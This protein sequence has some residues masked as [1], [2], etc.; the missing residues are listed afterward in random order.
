MVEGSFKKQFISG[1]LYTS[2][3]KYIGVFVSL[4]VT[5][6]LSRILTP[7]DFGVVAIATIFINIFS[8]VSTMGIAPA[9]VQNKEL[10][11]K[12]I[13]DIFSLTFWLGLILSGLFIAITPVIADYYDNKLLEDVLNA[14]T[15]CIFFSVLNTVPNALLLKEKQFKFIALRT[16]YVQ[17]SIGIIAITGAFYG[18]GVYALLVNPIIGSIIL[19]IVTY[20]KQKI[21][22]NLKFH[23]Y[24]INKIFSYSLYQILFNITSLII[25]NIDKLLIGSHL[26]TA[27]L[28]YYEKSYRLM[29]LPL[30]NIGHII[31][32]VLQPLLSEHQNDSDYLK[33]KYYTLIYFLNWVGFLLSPFL[34]FSAYE[35]IILIFGKQWEAS[36]ASF[37]IL[38]IAVAFIITMS[39]IEAIFR[40]ANNTKWLFISSLLGV[41]LMIGAVVL[42]L[43]EG[44]IEWVST[45]VVI[46]LFITLV[47]YNFVLHKV[48]F[49]LPSLNF[50][51]LFIQPFGT[52]TLLTMFL[53]I[54]EYF[55]H[56]ENTILMLLLKGLITA[57]FVLLAYI[58]GLIPKLNLKKND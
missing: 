4:C 15:I 14:L 13:E 34:F 5:I 33:T 46:A 3:A 27:S 50:A 17:I 16:L 6:V 52:G 2:L 21:C 19:F 39:P 42:G 35:L 53:F 56:L 49:K 57:L 12:N 36:V 24:S 8:L 58:F 37:R 26:G 10:T 9:I 48:V 1:V 43:R 18:L 40:S 23:T 11:Q 55:I 51:K 29:R 38:S 28:G 54:T 25:N 32:P 41:I 31:S 44:T 45:Y 20:R 30:D 47:I 22:F 7:D